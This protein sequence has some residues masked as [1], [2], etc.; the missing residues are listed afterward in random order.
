MLLFLFVFVFIFSCVSACG[1]ACS[2]AHVLL[3]TV[4]QE[5]KH[6]SASL[7]QQLHPGRN[8]PEP[9]NIVVKLSLLISRGRD[10]EQVTRRSLLYFARL[11]LDN[12]YVHQ[13]AAI[14]RSASAS[15]A[16]SA[17]KADVFDRIMDL[18]GHAHGFRDGFELVLQDVMDS[19]LMDELAERVFHVL[20]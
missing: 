12:D 20:T 9:P 16:S 19:S 3:P 10:C 1:W 7:C 4:S 17:E 5:L 14:F 6:Q 8:C 11:L 18:Y 15:L 13:I 2:P